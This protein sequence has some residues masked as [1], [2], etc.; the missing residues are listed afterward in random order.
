[1]DALLTSGA[2]ALLPGSQSWGHLEPA[3]GLSRDWVVLKANEADEAHAANIR[4]QRDR[5]YGN[6][7]STQATDARWVGDL[8][9]ILLD[10]WFSQNGLSSQW[11]TEDSAG[12]ADFILS[13]G[14]RLGVKTVKRQGA[15]AP[16]YTAQITKRHAKEPVD[17]YVFLSYDLPRK[18]MYLLGTLERDLFLKNARYYGPGD[19]VHANYIIRPG[20]EIYNIEIEKLRP[21]SALKTLSTY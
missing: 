17:F 15:P 16:H 1:M 5:K 4:A 2:P 20:H 8:G 13:N 10:R 14:I 12:N 7:F 9:E 19:A 18:A 6:I 21:A 3:Q 11:I